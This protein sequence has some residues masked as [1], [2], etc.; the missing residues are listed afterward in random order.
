MPSATPAASGTTAATGWT[1]ASGAAVVRGTA[2]AS[3]A[4]SDL[5]IEFWPILGLLGGLALAI[6]WAR[7]S[8]RPVVAAEW[9][10][11]ASLVLAVV[12]TMTAILAGDAATVRSAVLFSLVGAA[13]VTGTAFTGRPFSGRVFAWA[14]RGILAVGGL[15]ALVGADVD[16]FDAVTAPIGLALTIA[17]AIAMTRHPIGSWRALGIGLAVLLV[18]PLAADFVDPQLWRIVALGVAALAALVIGVQRRLQAP[19]ILGGAV[20]LV[21]AIVQLWPAITVLY[22]AVW[23]WLWLGIAGVALVVLAATY[24]RQLRLARTTIRSIAS[25]R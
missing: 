24:E 4:E 2:V 25:M 15:L 20:L 6:A 16:P 7:T 9:L 5:P 23:W 3:G 8:S 10:A 12:P 13:L 21:H 19:F 17:G 14:T 11:A 1:A 18:P 22:E